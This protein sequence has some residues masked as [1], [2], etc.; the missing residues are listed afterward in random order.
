MRRGLRGKLIPENALD[1]IG[2]Y[3]G[4]V[5]AGIRAYTLQWGLPVYTCP[6][7]GGHND[8]ESGG[9]ASHRCPW[10]RVD[11]E[12]LEFFRRGIKSLFNNIQ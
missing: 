4:G 5:S 6:K 1:E 9:A 8:L 11:K 2:L 12:A 10:Q 3:P 7:C